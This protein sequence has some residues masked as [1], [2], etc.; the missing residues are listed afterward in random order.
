MELHIFIL[1]A[2]IWKDQTNVKRG[3]SGIGWFEENPAQLTEI[4]YTR[5]T[6]L[7]SLKMK[8]LS[9]MLS[10]ISVDLETHWEA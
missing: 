5:T 8:K 4:F 10:V 3:S 1:F 6:N 9:Q 7:N 2:A